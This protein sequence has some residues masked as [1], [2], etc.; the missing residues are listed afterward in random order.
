[1]NE[2]HSMH[3][4]NDCHLTLNKEDVPKKEQS[5][6][7]GSLGRHWIMPKTKCPNCLVLIS[8]P[9]LGRH[10]A[11]CKLGLSPM[12]DKDKFKRTK[13]INSEFSSSIDSDRSLII[14]KVPCP[15]CKDYFRKRF[16]IFLIFSDNNI[17]LIVHFSRNSAFY[18]V[19]NAGS[20]DSRN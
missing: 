14:D 12:N 17:I 19:R 4:I 1:M 13:T 20:P 10:T 5:V 3:S 15:L 2:K 7:L 11:L 8:N 9:N 16:K 6:K 18:R